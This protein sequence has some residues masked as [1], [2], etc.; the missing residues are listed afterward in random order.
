MLTILPVIQVVETVMV[1]KEILVVAKAV[2]ASFELCFVAQVSLLHLLSVGRV[3]AGRCCYELLWP[4][5]P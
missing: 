2:F 5:D 4:T 1:A 3:T